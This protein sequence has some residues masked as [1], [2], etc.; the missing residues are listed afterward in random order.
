[1]TASPDIAANVADSWAYT[2]VLQEIL[3]QHPGLLLPTD[4]RRLQVSLQTASRFEDL[5]LAT[6]YIASPHRPRVPLALRVRSF[7]FLRAFGREVVFRDHHRA[8][9]ITEADKILNLPTTAEVYIYAFADSSGTDF[10]Q[11]VAIDLVKLRRVWA[12]STLR[13]ALGAKSVTFTQ[14]KGLVIS[15]DALWAQDCILYAHI[16]TPNFHSTSQVLDALSSEPW[17]WRMDPHDR[18]S[19]ARWVLYRSFA[20]MDIAVGR[21]T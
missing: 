1:M 6:D 7:E 12:D 15:L 2:S 8:G 10:A 14:G 19:L 18:N 17:L 9:G 16:A 20:G 21:R 11:W 13:T 5:N 4:R 3:N